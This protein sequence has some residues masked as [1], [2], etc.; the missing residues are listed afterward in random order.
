MWRSLMKPILVAGVPAAGKSTIGNLLS[1]SVGMPIYEYADFM[2]SVIGTNDRKN[3]LKIPFEERRP[4]YEAS[5]EAIAQLFSSNVINRYG[6]LTIH[7]SLYIDGR[8]NT[9]DDRH[10]RTLDMA[11]ILLIEA[12]PEIINARRSAD[13][14]RFRNYENVSEIASQQRCNRQIAQRLALT[15]SIP[16]I[17]VANNEKSL[18]VIKARDWLS[19]MLS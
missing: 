17:I 2:L 12:K 15:Y 10:Y 3:I 1:E 13:L 14:S 7:L 5:D 18:A 8:L 11:A 9:F 19:Q 16:M 6:L 4:I